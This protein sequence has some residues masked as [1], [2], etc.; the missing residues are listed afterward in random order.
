MSKEPFSIPPE[1]G[2]VSLEV[3][4]RIR[5]NIGFNRDTMLEEAANGEIPDLTSMREQMIADFECTK[6]SDK[7]LVDMVVS[8]YALSSK[9]SG[10]L[11]KWLGQD[12]FQEL[13]VKLV[14]TLGKELDRSKRRALAAYQTLQASKKPALNVHIRANNAVVG[15]N[16]QFN[17]HTHKDAT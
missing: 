9:L 3:R 6:P 12:R 11:L 5:N 13:T 2:H 14:N 17:A 8:D 1:A 10:Q 16:Q 15:N 7:M 4:D